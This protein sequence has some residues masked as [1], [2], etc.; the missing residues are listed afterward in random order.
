MTKLDLSGRVAVVT[1]ASAGIGE[2]I[3]RS[4]SLAG[5]AV[6]L[7]ARRKE[8][9]DELAAELAVCGG[10]ATVVAGDAAD[11]ATITAMLESA[12]TNFGKE[13]DLVV[14][15]AGRGLNGSVM[16]SNIGEWEEMI[17]TNVLG[18]ALLLRDAGHR[19]AKASEGKSGPG[20]LVS[21]RDIIVL[22]SVVGRHVSPF[23][24]MYG[25]TKFAVHGMV[26]GVRRELAGKGVRVSLIEPGFVV[27]EFQGVAGYDPK[28]VADIFEKIGPPLT[29]EDVAR[30][31]WFIASQPAGVHVSDVMIRP[32]RQEYP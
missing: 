19:M 4:L 3:A 18:A 6:V 13:A 20:V 14:I 30:M 5:A 21:P 17:R 16:S 7:N 12:R 31:V 22:G 11:S 15:N 8:K 27:S 23:S 25:G 9:L 10:M 29:P 26:E 1:G 2:A 28:W 32:T 24:S